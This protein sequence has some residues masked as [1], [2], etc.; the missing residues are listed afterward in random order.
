MNELAERIKHL[1]SP[2]ACTEHL[3]INNDADLICRVCGRKFGFVYGWEPAKVFVFEQYIRMKRPIVKFVNSNAVKPEQF[4]KNV[5]ANAMTL[6]MMLDNA[7]HYLDN[8]MFT[9]ENNEP[10]E[11]DFDAVSDTETEEE[12]EFEDY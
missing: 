6:S 4:E 8:N 2:S 11:L 1:F 5:E 9:A 10:E 7:A 3:Y 12:S